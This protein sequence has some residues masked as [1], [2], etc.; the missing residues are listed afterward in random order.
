[1][2]RPW[3]IIPVH[4]WATVPC[5]PG[6]AINHSYASLPPVGIEIPI[7]RLAWQSEP[8]PPILLSCFLSPNRRPGERHRAAAARH[9]RPCWQ[10]MRAWRY[11]GDVAASRLVPGEH[12]HRIS[13]PLAP[14]P[15]DEPPKL[16]TTAA[17][18][19]P[20]LALGMREPAFR[21]CM[22]D[23]VTVRF[24]YPVSIIKSAFKKTL[25]HP[26]RCS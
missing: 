26:C 21:W 25:L 10:T 12:D 16:G 11:Y 8:P 3:S 7:D 14:L 18:C 5:N 6:G 15:S 19:A 4:M 13:L 23:A 2:N 1:V 24:C 17:S 20:R 22:R 9:C